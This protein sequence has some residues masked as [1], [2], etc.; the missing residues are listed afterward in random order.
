MHVC[1]NERFKHALGYAYMYVCLCGYARYVCLFV[2]PKPFMVR[3]PPR[4]LF[5]PYPNLPPCERATH[6][7]SLR[8]LN[9][10]RRGSA[11]LGLAVGHGGLTHCLSYC[12]PI[13]EEPR[14]HKYGLRHATSS[15]RQSARTGAGRQTQPSETGSTVHNLFTLVF[16]RRGPPWL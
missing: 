5:T 6:P 11:Q 2:S 14:L 4:P 16:G 1:M 15:A 12:V 3:R 7:P 10:D 8:D 9:L 13:V